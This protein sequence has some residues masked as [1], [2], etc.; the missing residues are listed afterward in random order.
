MSAPEPRLDQV[1]RWMQSVI[2]HPGGASEGVDSPQARQHV[3]ITLGELEQVINRSQALSSADRLDIYVNAY[4]ARLMECLA[5][6]FAVVRH[7]LGDELFDA[8]AFGYLQHFPSRSYTLGQLGALFPRYLTES[9]LH[10]TGAPEE[11]G[12]TWPDFI[13]ELATLERS[14]YEVFDGPGTEPT[15]TLQASDLGAIAPS[16]GRRRDW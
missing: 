3:D 7:A 1:Q 8:V 4:H 5:E 12:P 15:G 14:L 13:I 10:A 2:T 9:R 16:S 6:E 11:A